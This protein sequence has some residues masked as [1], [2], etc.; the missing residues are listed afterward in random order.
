M[1]TKLIPSIEYIFQTSIIHTKIDE[2]LEA[3]NSNYPTDFTL[4]KMEYTKKILLDNLKFTR[5]CSKTPKELIINTKRKITIPNNSNR[6]IA[7]IWKKHNKNGARCT[8]KKQHECNYCGIHKKNNPHGDFNKP[9][10]D[11]QQINFDK[12]GS[13][14]T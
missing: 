9:I 3:I 6:C 7:R 8:R 5:Q 10:S 1:T 14:P 11:I 4:K 13:K 12:Y 2:L